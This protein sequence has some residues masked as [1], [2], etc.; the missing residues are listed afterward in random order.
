MTAGASAA[1]L[2]LLLV[3]FLGLRWIDLGHFMLLT[4]AAVGLPA[5]AWMAGPG[6]LLP[7][8][9]LGA[10]LAAAEPLFATGLLILSWAR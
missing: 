7:P 4:D 6:G 5:L 2:A 3:A 1:W 10:V 9:A 8:S